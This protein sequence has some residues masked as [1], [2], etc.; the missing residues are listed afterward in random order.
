MSQFQWWRVSEYGTAQAYDDTPAIRERVNTE[1]GWY[2]NVEGT[3]VNGGIVA[4]SFMRTDEQLYDAKAWLN[5]GTRVPAG[6][7][8]TIRD[9][10]T[11]KIIKQWERK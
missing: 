8:T 1:R 10:I 4:T 7:R 11:N 3:I 5:T 6:A 2:G 9:T